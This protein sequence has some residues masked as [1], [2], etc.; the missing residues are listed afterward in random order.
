MRGRVKPALMYNDLFV[1]L[2]QPLHDG[3]EKTKDI[4][5]VKMSFVLFIVL[6]Q[7]LLRR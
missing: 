1:S 3:S 4:L 7:L 5:V 2:F 6:L